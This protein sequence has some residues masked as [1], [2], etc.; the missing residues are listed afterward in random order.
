MNHI[1]TVLLCS[2]AVLSIYIAHL[3][4]QFGCE[5]DLGF[6]VSVYNEDDKLVIE[7]NQNHLTLVPNVCD[8]CSAPSLPISFA[9]RFRFL[10]A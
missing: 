8:K 1:T 6:E 5:Q 7:M 2:S 9:S 4:R 3:H 10:S